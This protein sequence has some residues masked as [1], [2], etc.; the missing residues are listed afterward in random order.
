MQL[1]IDRQQ[2]SQHL[3]EG[4]ID[5]AEAILR[6][7]VH[8]GFCLATCPTYQLLGSEL[9]SPR[10]RIYQ[11]K[12]L[13]EGATATAQTQAHLDRCLTC[14]NCETT[15]PSG[16]R[17]SELIATGR[18]LVEQQV[19]RPLL[20]QLMIDAL[21]HTVP[22]RRRIRPLIQ[23]GRALGIPLAKAAETLPA[24]PP[25][26]KAT[27]SAGSIILFQ[28]CVQDELAPSTNRH[29]KQ[30]LESLGYKVHQLNQ[31]GCCGALSH[32]LSAEAKSQQMV[33][34]NI[35]QWLPLIEHE[36]AQLVVAAS[37][38]GS[39]VQDYPKQLQDDA[40]YASAA[41]QVA[42]ALI[43]PA[44]LLEPHL[45]Q[46]T[47]HPDT[48]KQISYHPPCSQQH[49]LHTDLSVESLLEALGCELLPVANRHSCC[50][51]AG[52]YSLLQASL[53]KQL[54]QRK[55]EALEQQQPTLIATANI[56]C[57]HHLQHGTKTPVVHWV[58][59]VQH[60]R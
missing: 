38:C 15:C 49:A 22:Y 37:G 45:D 60:K 26:V 18:T 59:L 32:H 57:Q 42:D 9:D 2:L 30:L 54:R 35:D 53:S 10:G 46:L 47:L 27:N 55:L 58:E 56:G 48:P 13:M 25:S 17:Y 6:N 41:Q 36:Q 21:Q 1:T 52:T 16:I 3:S 39:M 31:E 51:A 12:Q 43:D 4:E 24:R 34:N 50:G 33:R 7:C 28:G 8:C 19:K 23:L 5:R 29:L 20:E 11:I 40:S 14:R 44:Q